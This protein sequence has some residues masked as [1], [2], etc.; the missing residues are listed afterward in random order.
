MKSVSVRELQHHLAESLNAA[1]RGEEIEVKRR[2]R[3]IA[4]LVPV[5]VAETHADWTGAKTRLHAQFPAL[6]RGRTVA[7]FIDEGRGER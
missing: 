2:G 1:A 5:P 4:R 7:E 3:P 6:V